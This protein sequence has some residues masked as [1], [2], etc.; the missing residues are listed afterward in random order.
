MKSDLYQIHLNRVSRSFAFGISELQEP[1]REYVGFAYLFCRLID[2]IEDAVW[3]IGLGANQQQLQ[4]TQLIGF[5]D[6]PPSEQAFELWRSRV[7]AGL[8]EGEQLLLADS[9][10][11]FEDYHRLPREVREILRG[12]ILTMIRGMSAFVSIKEGNEI[13]LRNLLGIESLLFFVAGVVGEI[14][15]GLANYLNNSNEKPT[16]ELLLESFHFG[17]FLQKINILKDQAEDAQRGLFFF[18]DKNAVVVTL[19][20]HAT[21]AKQYVLSLPDAW[22]DF[23]LFCTFSLSLGLISLPFIL[24]PD[25]GSQK[26]SRDHTKMLMSHLKELNSKVSQLGEFIQ[27]GIDQIP[28]VRTPIDPIH[29]DRLQADQLQED[30]LQAGRG[31]HSR[32]DPGSLYEGQLSQDAIH[33]FFVS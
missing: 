9:Y 33:N 6:Q 18:G 21:K 29:T 15:T 26:I 19:R 17:L 10:L 11:L 28:M 5:L 8:P 14:L 24:N 2:T 13:R 30:R 20:E 12:P 27:N 25:E 32:F 22:G 4:F 7:P 3:P 31:D 16:A 1:L 23:R